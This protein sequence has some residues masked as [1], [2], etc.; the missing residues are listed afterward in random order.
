MT[1]GDKINYGFPF[2]LSEVETGWNVHPLD[3]PADQ[4]PPIDVDLSK[5]YKNDEDALRMQ[6]VYFDK[7]STF[8]PSLV[9]DNQSV[10]FTFQ[11]IRRAQ[12][13]LNNGD[14]LFGG[15]IVTI[16]NVKHRGS[17]GHS[18]DISRE[19]SRGYLK[20][21]KSP[22]RDRD[23]SAGADEADVDCLWELMIVGANSR[24][25]LIDF[26]I[27]EGGFKKSA[28]KVRFKHLMSGKY[29]TQDEADGGTI[30]LTDEQTTLKKSQTYFTLVQ[31]SKNSPLRS[32]DSVGIF[33]QSTTFS[34]TNLML[35]SEFSEPMSIQQ[36]IDCNKWIKPH[37]P[38]VP[39]DHQSEFDKSTV[40]CKAKKGDVEAYYFV[41]LD[42]SE[43]RDILRFKATLILLNESISCIVKCSTSA[44]L[45][46][47]FQQFLPRIS[48]IIDQILDKRSVDLQLMVAQD[49][50]TIK[51]EPQYRLTARQARYALAIGLMDKLFDCVRIPYE[52]KL[53]G[54]DSLSEPVVKSFYSK[55]L[56][57]LTKIVELETR[58]QKYACQYTNFL[59]SFC[60]IRTTSQ[61][62]GQLSLLQHLVKAQDA[63]KLTRH[64]SI[65]RLI[66]NINAFGAHSCTQLQMLLIAC[67]HGSSNDLFMQSQLVRGIF[68]QENDLCNN[69][70][71]FKIEYFGENSI[72][73]F[74]SVFSEWHDLSLIK[75]IHFGR[76]NSEDLSRPSQSVERINQFYRY[77]CA[78][79]ETLSFLSSNQSKPGL[80]IC[81]RMF[82]LVS[83]PV[84]MMA[85][86][87]D[88]VVKAK[89]IDIAN[90]CWVC[91]N[92]FA[93][94]STASHL[95]EWSEISHD[96]VVFNKNS[97]RSSYLSVNIECIS[98]ACKR[99]L[100]ACLGNRKNSMQTKDVILVTAVLSLQQ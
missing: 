82:P 97:E 29:M 94:Q 92:S 65:P 11:F 100:H 77:F 38:F 48:L 72:R 59:L 15:D 50:L 49:A 1:R 46:A 64:L 3:Q 47:C 33:T 81:Q 78:S 58:C 40:S 28:Q 24:G 62:V 69:K 41:K 98:S 91:Q 8:Y 75:F 52:L 22:A 57:F 32:K 37:D 9:S 63:Y 2:Y 54:R 19:K 85:D 79:L 60:D 30:V 61:D 89:I 96:P 90:N 93:N 39:L 43:K 23:E 66:D 71:G 13:W 26:P 25:K 73:V 68:P 56:T 6:R 95:Y 70:L 20:K 87:I 83:V 55:V 18:I 31:L 7:Q 80:L 12:P 67:R 14:C 44:E 35:T 5:V 86:N 51:K 74:D 21:L 45:S 4:Q 76:R 17:I 84:I 99:L 36:V 27:T 88:K 34:S 53:I 16:V 10:S 42:G